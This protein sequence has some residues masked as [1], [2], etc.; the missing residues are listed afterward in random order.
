MTKDELIELST[1]WE[2]RDRIWGVMRAHYTAMGQKQPGSFADCQAA[3]NDLIWIAYQS[4]LADARLGDKPV[5][6]V[7]EHAAKTA[8]TVAEFD[9][10]HDR[11]WADE[12]QQLL[13]RIV[14]LEDQ[15]A[16]LIRVAARLSAKKAA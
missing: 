14:E 5:A 8:I 6:T 2:A 12:Q 11:M 1:K 16:S 3:V 15:N 9:A 4:G 7:N 13:D 10:E